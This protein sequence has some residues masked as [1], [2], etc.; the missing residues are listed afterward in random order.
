M[1]ADEAIASYLRSKGFKQ[2]EQAFRSE[3]GLPLDSL[4][5]EAKKPESDE[6]SVP[7]FI[8]HYNEV[9]LKNPAAYEQSYGRLRIWIEDSLDKYK[10]EMRK[11]LFPIFVHSY[12]DLVGKE[13]H[14]QAQAFFN[15]YKSDHVEQHNSDVSRMGSITQKNQIEESDLAQ[16]FLKNRYG[17]RMSRF[18]FEL[19]LAF[20]QDNKFILLTRLICNHIAIRVDSDRPT[21]AMDLDEGVGISGVSSSALN[22]FNNQPALLGQLPPDPWLVTEMEKAIREDMTETPHAKDDLLRQVKGETFPD[23]PARENV[24][25]PYPKFTDV[26]KNIEI[27]K[28][29]RNRV[30]LGPNSLPSICAYTFH[31]TYDTLNCLEI[32]EDSTICCAGLSESFVRV[33]NVTGQKLKC[34]SLDD[35][36]KITEAETKRLVGHSGP[37]YGISISADKKYA[38]SCSEDRTVRMWSLDTFT[39][40]AVYKGHNYPVWDVEFSP[41]GSYFVSGSH[42]RTAKLWST[43]TINP[44]RLFVGHSSDVD[45]VKFHPNCNYIATGSSDTQIRLWNVQKGNCVRLMKGHKGAVTTLA[46]SPDGRNLASAGEEND[47]KLWDLASGKLIKNLLGHSNTVYSLA[48]SRDGKQLASGGAD[49]TVRIWDVLTSDTHEV[50]RDGG[51][52]ATLQAMAT[53]EWD[54]HS[55]HT[56]G[57][58]Q[59]KAE[60]SQHSGSFETLST[61]ASTDPNLIRQIHT[62]SWLRG[63]VFDLTQTSIFNNL[64]LLVILMNTVV[65]SMETVDELNKAYGWY[66]TVVDDAFLGIYILE[67]V[68]KL[69]SWRLRYFTSGWNNFDLIIVVVSIITWIVPYYLTTAVTFNVRIFRLLRLFRAVRAI[70]S[71]RVLRTISF[72]R[73]LQVIISTVLKS[74]PAMGNIVLLS[75]IMLYAFAVFATMTYRDID[76]RRFGNLGTSC[77]RVFQVMTFDLWSE[78]YKDNEA[79]SWSIYYF[80]IVVII[81]MNFIFLNLFVAVIVNNL[82]SARD[83]LSLRRRQKKKNSADLDFMEVE[84]REP[85]R[86]SLRHLDEDGLLKDR[87]FEEENGIDNYY[88]PNLPTRQKE[89]LSSYFALLASLELNQHLQ[90][91]QL[92]VLDDLGM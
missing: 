52:S 50:K 33:W 10:L 4:S 17:V 48:F 57:S 13:M 29:V 88:S 72:L 89:L 79:K 11:I 80:V 24:P 6:A 32:S 86:T 19:M 46:F 43:D 73:S 75:G 67:S 16:T 30:A 71:L 64:I 15:S 82:Q 68:L 37:V 53:S 62:S 63:K 14:D 56:M 40:L 49:N 77:F 35:S 85:S 54:F 55:V 27:L 70:R 76:P 5:D 42:D 38:V 44:L 51:G 25:L 69:F 28:Q 26:A 3:A 9:E 90:Q 45:T 41:M 34:A 36:G 84:N 21:A 61:Q 12:L 18:S 2:S 91:K 47:I 1:D 59:T 22:E 83:R 7:D 39:N 58:G 66:L 74:I 60:K 20:L 78:V 87:I 81:V 65:L 23:S 92:K 31:N 8:L